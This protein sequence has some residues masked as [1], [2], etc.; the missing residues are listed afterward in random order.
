V[1]VDGGRLEVAGDN[2]QVS[3]LGDIEESTMSDDDGVVFERTL[4][5]VGDV[6]VVRIKAR[7]QAG[8]DDVWSAI[9]EPPRLEGW[10][11]SVAG[12]LRVGGEFT[13]LVLASGWDG[14]GRIAACVERQ[15][16]SVRMWE[17]EG[18]E[19]TVEPQLFAEGDHT[20]LQLEVRG[21]KLELVWA[22]GAGWQEHLEDLGSY[23]LGHNRAEAPA[24]SGARFKELE[25]HYRVMPIERL[26]G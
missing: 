15:K 18:S 7:Y 19:H 24:G 9:S 12:D 20:I 26:S 1:I 6:G 10:F 3:L 16:L 8:V 5:S 25:P 14:Q 21:V 22:Y 23:L 4:H 13:A 11:G 17:D 2:R